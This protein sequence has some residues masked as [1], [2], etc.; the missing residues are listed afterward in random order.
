MRRQADRRAHGQAR[1]HE[2][3]HRGRRAARRRRRRVRDL[4]RARTQPHQHR[5]DALARP[6][7]TGRTRC[8]RSAACSPP[9]PGS[10]AMSGRL[11][12]RRGRA[13]PRRRAPRRRPSSRSSAAR[14]SQAKVARLLARL[15]TI[16]GVR[17][18]SLKSSE[19]PE[20]KGDAACPANRKSDP[21]FSI[22]IAFAVP[23]APKASV[24]STGPGRGSLRRRARP[25]R[26]RRPSPR[27]P[28]AP[29]PT[30]ARTADG[31]PPEIR[32]GH[33]RHGRRRSPRCGCSSSRRSARRRASLGDQLT[34][35][36]VRLADA[37]ARASTAEQARAT[38]AR[39]YATVARLGKAVPVSADVPSLVFQ[40]ESA[41]RKAKVD[42]RAVHRARRRAER[43][44][45][46][47]DARGRGRRRPVGAV[48][49]QVRGRLL[50]PAEAARA[51]RPLLARQG[52]AGGRQRPAADDRRP[53]AQPR[54][55]RAAARA[56]RRDRPRLRRRPARPAARAGAATVPPASQTDSPS[57]RPTP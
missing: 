34:L 27:R 49:L 33:R 24:D 52:H 11:G 54:E 36:E 3:G 29:A 41:A 9:T 30:A 32:A 13:D 45:G 2:R 1:A 55:R 16:D 43:A 15:R 57:P 6:A 46:A 4:P 7:S 51:D 35:A 25:A 26:R 12:R 47:R 10:S 38:Y 53:D 23:G 8:A 22:A 37:N 42:F 21:R 18:V 19:K 40:L 5:D 48:L 56:G 17:K 39:D 20:A 14:R 28:R 50:R 31:R 44:R